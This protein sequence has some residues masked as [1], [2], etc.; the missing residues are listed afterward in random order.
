MVR[1][2]DARSD[3]DVTNVFI[4]LLIGMSVPPAVAG[5]STI[6]M[7]K[8]P[9][10]SHVSSATHPLLQVV[11]TVSIE[12]CESASTRNTSAIYKVGSCGNEFG[13]IYPQSGQE[14]FSRVT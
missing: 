1:S 8:L 10:I 9:A 13:L 12:I 6:R 11:L 2:R 3:S 14:S 4:T 7:Q 5:R